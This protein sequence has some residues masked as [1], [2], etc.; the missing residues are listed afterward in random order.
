MENLQRFIAYFWHH[1]WIVSVNVSQLWLLLCNRY[2]P[3]NIFYAYIVIW[4]GPSCDCVI[5]VEARLKCFAD[6][7]YTTATII[8]RRLL[9]QSNYDARNMQWIA[10][11]F[12]LFWVPPPPVDTHTLTY[13]PMQDVTNTMSCPQLYSGEVC[14]LLLSALGRLFTSFLQLHGFSLGLEDILVKPEVCQVFVRC[15]MGVCVCVSSRG[16]DIPL[17]WDSG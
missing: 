8:D 2:H 10:V 4:F 3:Q 17:F 5:D 7:D 13:T 14:N 16:E 12:P 9:L 15:V 11:N 6:N 1:N